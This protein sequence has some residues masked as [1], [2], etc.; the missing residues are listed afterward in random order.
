MLPPTERCL[1]EVPAE[2]LE[3]AADWLVRSQSED[4]ARWAME[5]EGWHSR[6]P[7]HRA[8][9]AR[10]QAVLQDFGRMP[11]RIGRP[12]LERLQAR[13]RRRALQL[14]GLGAL[15]VPAG[16]WSWKLQP[17]LYWQADFQTARGEQRLL[18]LA[19][20]TRVTL[21]T[22]TAVA[23]HF[24]EEVRRLHLLAGEIMVSTAPD[25]SSRKRP[26]IVQTDQGAL[27]PIGTRFSVRDL[28]GAVRLAV[29]EGQVRITAAQGEARILQAGEQLLFQ[30]EGMGAIEPIQV[31]DALWT[32][33]MLVAR[34]MPLEV[35]VAEMSRYRSGI[36]RCHPRVADLR[37]SGAFPLNDTEA[38]LA[39]LVQTRP[40]AVR[41]LTNYWI[42][43]EP[44]S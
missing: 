41:R 11:V 34:N 17:W 9:W 14:L 6:S 5:F 43:L 33:G 36:L 29:F 4:P 40:L 12:A 24:D 3:E 19:D 16:W 7:A 22:A 21:N 31:G 28:S 26:F 39:M 35:W 13:G 32:E 30:R 20:G 25:P 18:E 1:G 10:A 38:S 15:A 44:A 23:I 2:L 42:S 37:V 27:Q 8:A